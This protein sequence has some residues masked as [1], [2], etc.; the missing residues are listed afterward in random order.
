M[1]FLIPFVK[2]MRFNYP[3]AHITLMLNQPWQADIFNNMGVD[4]FVFSHFSTKGSNSFIRSIKELRKKTYDLIIMP[5]SSVEDA[6]ICSMLSAKNK[7][8][9]F[10][11]HRNRV[12]THTFKNN[13]RNV[14]AALSCLYLIP[15]LGGE[16]KLP[17]CHL[18]ELTTEEIKEGVVTKEVIYQ[19]HKLCIAY[20]RGARGDKLL[21]DEVWLG[22]LNKIEVDLNYHIQWIEILSPD[23]TVPLKDEILTYRSDNMRHLASFLKNMD[24]F[25]CCDTGPLHLADAADVTCLGLFNK[26]NPAIYGVLGVNSINIEDI[27]NFDVKE[28]FSAY[29]K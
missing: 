13:D 16:L 18:L 19:G 9:T 14:H 26:T 24:A 17:I 20:F 29:S 6:M 11:S 10:N 3:N 12:F 8:S 21:S 2:Q 23:V 28:N 1:Y 22:I 27:V 25:I 7:V 15:L 5:Y 4:K